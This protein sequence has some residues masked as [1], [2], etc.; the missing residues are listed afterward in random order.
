M[1]AKC[2][3]IA[4]IMTLG[5]SVVTSF[6]IPLGSGGIGHRLVKRMARPDWFPSPTGNAKYQYVSACGNL[7]GRSVWRN[8]KIGPKKARWEP[9]KDDAL[10]MPSLPPLEI[11]IKPAPQ[12]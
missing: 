11:E 4:F 5:W 9:N 3:L 12:E 6:Q 8:L 10:S 2:A 1:G 7:C